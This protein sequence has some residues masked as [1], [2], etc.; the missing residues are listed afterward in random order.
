MINAFF[1][2]CIPEWLIETSAQ[3][4]TAKPYK[5]AQSKTTIQITYGT[6]K[7]PTTQFRRRHAH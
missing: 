2:G 5:I 3:P 1:Y 4:A 6:Q 7:H